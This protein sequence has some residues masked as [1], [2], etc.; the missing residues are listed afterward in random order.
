MLLF[1][2]AKYKF[3][4]QVNASYYG[5]DVKDKLDRHY[6]NVNYSYAVANGAHCNF[7][8]QWVTTPNGK[9]GAEHN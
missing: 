6:G 1:W 9:A 5:V 4:D 3:N 2:G 8:C 7:R